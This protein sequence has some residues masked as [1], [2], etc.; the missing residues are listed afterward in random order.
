MATWAASG[1]N[2][3]ADMRYRP[4]VFGIRAMTLPAGSLTRQKLSVNSAVHPASSSFPMDTSVKA[5]LGAC[6]TFFNLNLLTPVPFRTLSRMSPR[7]MEL[8]TQPSAAVTDLW[9]VG[10]YVM[11]IDLSGQKCEV[12]PLSRITSCEP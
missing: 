7:P 5:M 6:A 9:D 2:D 10:E 12:V 4:F 8:S 3:G 1:T 11:N